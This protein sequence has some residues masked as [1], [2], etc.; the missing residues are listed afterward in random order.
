MQCYSGQSTQS[1]VCSWPI[2][3]LIYD[4]HY[5]LTTLILLSLNFMSVLLFLYLF[6][7][8]TLYFCISESFF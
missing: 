4:D 8:I 3:A 5:K 7:C 2:P 1:N 6:L